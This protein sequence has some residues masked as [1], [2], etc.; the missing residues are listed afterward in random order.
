MQC[1]KC[2]DGGSASRELWEPRGWAPNLGSGVREDFLEEVITKL[3]L[4]VHKSLPVCLLHLQHRL[5]Y[6]RCS[7]I[8]CQMNKNVPGR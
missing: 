8:I 1:N 2:S 6:I 5:V 7:V 4:K 3:K